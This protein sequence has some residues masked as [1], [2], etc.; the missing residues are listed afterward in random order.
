MPKV[1]ICLS[2]F[3]VRQQIMLRYLKSIYYLSAYKLSIS[4]KYDEHNYALLYLRP[5]K[6]FIMVE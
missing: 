3:F 1:E 5:N 4:E 2:N 6:Q